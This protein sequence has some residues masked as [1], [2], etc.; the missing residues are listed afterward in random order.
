M[1]TA[2]GEPVDP[3]GFFT[4]PDAGE[5]EP[6]EIAARLVEDCPEFLHLKIGQPVI[7]FVLRAASKLRAGRTVLGEMSLPRFMGT[8]S[9]LGT[10]LLARACGG[11][12]PDFIMLLDAAWWAEASPFHR[13]ALVHHELKHAG[14]ARDREGEPRFNDDGSPIWAIEPHDLEEFQDTVRQ[15]GAWSPDI[16]PFLAALREGGGA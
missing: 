7:M 9:P 6:R 5:H 2:D 8:L 16:P 1:K 14:H 10:W 3:A 13:A 4:L 15:F 11:V 12:L